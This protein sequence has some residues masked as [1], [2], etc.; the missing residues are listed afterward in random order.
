MHVDWDSLFRYRDIDQCWNMTKDILFMLVNKHIPKVTIKSEF[1][2]PWFDSDCYVAC[3]EKE[4]LRAKYKRTKNEADGIKFS[5]ARRNFKKLTALKMQE[6]LTDHED[7]AMITKKFWSYVKSSSN[8]HRIPECMEYQG[9]LRNNPKDQSELFND[10]FFAQ[11]SSPS[12][13]DIPI[14]HSNDS[15]FPE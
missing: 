15:R 3:R 12:L 1:Q 6:N 11:F 2:P 4:R 10:F 14:D 7:T 5:N 13:Y 8:S 9:A